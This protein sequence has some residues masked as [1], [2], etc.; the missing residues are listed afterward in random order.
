MFMLPPR[1]QRPP[2]VIGGPRELSG[3]KFL[4]IANSPTE[5]YR[6]TEKIPREREQSEGEGGICKPP[7]PMECGEKRAPFTLANGRRGSALRGFM[8]VLG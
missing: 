5:S 3:G 7:P 2:G 8:I 6:G 1:S 4:P